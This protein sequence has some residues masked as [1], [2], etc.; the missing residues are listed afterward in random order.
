MK[1]RKIKDGK[2][3]LREVPIKIKA[4]YGG[5]VKAEGVGIFHIMDIDEFTEAWRWEIKEDYKSTLR[6]THWMPL[7]EPPK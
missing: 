4:E 1:W 5:I 3:P 2:P 7:P 6:P